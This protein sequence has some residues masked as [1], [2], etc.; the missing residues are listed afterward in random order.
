MKN[1]LKA[2]LEWVCTGIV[3]LKSYQ[4]DMCYILCTIALYT[5][6]IYIY[7]RIVLLLAA[8]SVQCNV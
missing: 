6:L 7:L 3:F 4:M 1:F 2:L 5:S 8:F